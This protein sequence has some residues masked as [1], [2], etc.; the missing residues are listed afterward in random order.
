MKEIPQFETS[1]L[2]SIMAWYLTGKVSIME[3]CDILN[4]RLLEKAEA[5]RE[6]EERF[7]R[8]VRIVSKRILS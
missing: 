6:Q 7:L 3:L 2:N 1:D 5:S 8:R 4:A